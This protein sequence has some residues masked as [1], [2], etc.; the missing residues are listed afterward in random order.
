MTNQTAIRHL[1]NLLRRAEDWDCTS[2][3]EDRAIKMGLEALQHVEHEDNKSLA[4]RLFDYAKEAESL[5]RIARRIPRVDQI[6]D[7]IQN[8]NYDLAQRMAK[9]L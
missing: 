5:S 1:T 3:A 9:E 8:A 4:M 7:E 2:D 6:M